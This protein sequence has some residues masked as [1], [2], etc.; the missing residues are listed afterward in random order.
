MV[1]VPA[2]RQP[3][4][5][6][7]E[8]AVK[9]IS[10]IKR[11]SDVTLSCAELQSRSAELQRLSGEADGR[12][13]QAMASV[14]QHQREW[15]AKTTLS[16]PPASG[17]ALGAAVTVLE[18]IPMAGN[19]ASSV[20]MSSLAMPSPSAPP[21]EAPVAAL[22][23]VFDAG[24][25]QT[26]RYATAARHEHLRQLHVRK[27]CPQPP[28]T[29]G[30][31]AAIPGDRGAPSAGESAV[32]GEVE[33]EARALEHRIAAHQQALERASAAL[34]DPVAERTQQAVEAAM[35]AQQ[36]L[37]PDEARHQELVGQFL[38]RSCPLR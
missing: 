36:A 27:A 25:L 34:T 24:K 20:L 5:G 14:A 31:G 12:A 11:L 16:S 13:D 35:A 6:A 23:S 28:Q 4:G 17:V 8:G 19:L 9:T 18:A 2:L 21:A 30:P 1:L 32:C 37:Y 29:G 26:I 7:T 10:S 3:V 15:T 38:A 33:R 22:Q